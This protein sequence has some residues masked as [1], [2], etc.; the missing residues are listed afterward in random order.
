MSISL[1]GD[2]TETNALASDPNHVMY[3]VHN[4]DSIFSQHTSVLH[5]ADDVRRRQVSTGTLSSRPCPWLSGAGGCRRSSAAHPQAASLAS[6]HPATSEPTGASPMARARHVMG[7]C[8]MEYCSLRY[9][10][11]F[12]ARKECSKSAWMIWRAYG[13]GRYCLPRK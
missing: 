8:F 13:P 2:I 3:A 10:M 9:G 5:V 1:F 7:C 11:P 12:N 4:S 6:P